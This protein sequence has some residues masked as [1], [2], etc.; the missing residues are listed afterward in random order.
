LLTCG[1]VAR[2]TPC[3]GFLPGLAHGALFQAREGQEGHG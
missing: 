1:S 2:H 3:H